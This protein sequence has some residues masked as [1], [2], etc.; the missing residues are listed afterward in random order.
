MSPVATLGFNIFVLRVCAPGSAAAT[1]LLL[2]HT[3]PLFTR[4]GMLHFDNGLCLLE[5]IQYQGEGFQLGSRTS[6]NRMNSTKNA[7]VLH[8]H[9]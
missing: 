9:T 6:S 4:V 7:L 8:P 3:R 1:S 2:F 5:L